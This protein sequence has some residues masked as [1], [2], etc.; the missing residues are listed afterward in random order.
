MKIGTLIQQSAGFKAFIP[1]EFPPKESLGL[2]DLT[3]KLHAKASLML[4]K[5]DGITQLLPDL[6]F[7]IFMYVRKEAAYSTQ[8][9]GTKATMIDAILAETEM[10]RDLPPD[11]D[12][13]L[14]YIQAM[15]YGLKRLEKLPLSSR[16]IREIHKILMKGARSNHYS[17][18]GE[19]RTSQNWIGGGSPQTARFVP[20]PVDQMQRSL[21]DLEKFL[22]VQ[23]DMLPLI[24]TALAHAQFETIHPFL[25]GNGRTG[26]LL[27]TFYLCQQKILERPVLY[28]SEYLKQ[29]RDNY[30][31]LLHGYHNGNIVLWINFFLEG[32]AK[33]ADQAVKIAR[34]ITKLREKDISTIH[35]LGKR[36]ETATVVLKNLYRLP[37]INVKKIE[38]WTNLSRPSANKL[39]KDFVKLGIL[40]QR[41]EKTQYARQFE[42]KEYL[43]IFAENKKSI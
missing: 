19:F 31:D 4:G 22:Y 28:L 2:T 1:A 43:R 39:V 38:E 18:L 12:D 8:I 30:F 36:A 34:Q 6:D 3:H 23:D 15:N 42:Y 41:D 26:R 25:D 29:N 16:L 11:V 9:E 40:K 24:K 21:S 14:H 35:V 10:T 5:L 32:V 37:I 17:S 20:P 27:V 7:F 33:V 13:I